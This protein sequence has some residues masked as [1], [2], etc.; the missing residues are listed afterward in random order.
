MRKSTLNASRDDL[1][2]N[3]VELAGIT[4]G[5][6]LI[7]GIDFLADEDVSESIPW[8]KLNP[9]RDRIPLEPLKPNNRK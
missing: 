1:C 8:T 9:S 3:D 4:G 5:K 6:L 2:L 7:N